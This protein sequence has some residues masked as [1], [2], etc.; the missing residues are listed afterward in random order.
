MNVPDSP[1]I[2]GRHGQP[3]SKSSRLGPGERRGRWRRRIVGRILSPL[4]LGQRVAPCISGSTLTLGHVASITGEGPIAW[5]RSG[6]TGPG[7]R[8]R[9][10]GE[11][12][13]A[14]G[15]IKA[16]RGLAAIPLDRRSEQV[17]R[18]IEAGVEFLLSVDPASPAYPAET[19]PSPNWFKFGFPSGYIADILQI[20]EVLV[21]LGLAG[22]SR[23]AGAVNLVRSKQDS[24]GRWAKRIRLRRQDVGSV[25][26]GPI[27]EQVG[28]PARL[29]RAQGCHRGDELA[30]IGDFSGPKRSPPRSAQ[31]V[32]RVRRRRTADPKRSPRSVAPHPPPRAP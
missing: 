6:T 27:A 32:R 11:L 18:A 25:R 26:G 23:L 20:L 16:L 10:N 4:E 1:T 12:P 3:T 31:A 7:F 30:L 17:R 22:D 21:D 9:L 24:R 8:C 2:R 14:W 13:C 29:P 28:H 5:F 15:A 19:R